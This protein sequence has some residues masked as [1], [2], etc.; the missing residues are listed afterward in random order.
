MRTTDDS[1]PDSSRSRSRPPRPP[2]GPPRPRPPPGPPRPPPPPPPGPRP[3][4]PPPPWPP[5]KLAPPPCCPLVGLSG[6]SE[7]QTALA[8]SVGHRLH[9]AVVLVPGAVE[10]DARDPGLLGPLGDALADLRR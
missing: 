4:P 5:P 8:G 7:L 3:R 6:M 10:H 2:P 9:S 1:M